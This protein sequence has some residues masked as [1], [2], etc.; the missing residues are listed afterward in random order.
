[1]MFIDAL[2]SFINSNIY[3]KIL[4]ERIWHEVAEAILQTESD[5]VPTIIS[6][7]PKIS[8]FFDKGV[9]CWTP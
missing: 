4:A 3:G 9:H 1:M 6:P 7:N 2:K 8:P 5:F